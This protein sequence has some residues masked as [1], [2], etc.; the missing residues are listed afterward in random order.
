MLKILVLKEWRMALRSQTLAATLFPL[1]VLLGIAFTAG[2]IQQSRLH[3]ERDSANAHFRMQWEQL[4]AGDPHSAAHFG[5]YLFKPLATLSSFDKGVDDISGYTMRVE[6]HIQ[7]SMATPP[8]RPADAYLRFG[9]LTMA[10]VLQLFFPLFILFYCYNSYTQEQAS[11]TLRLLLLQGV[12]KAAI[13]LGKAVLHLAL[14]NGMLLC[15]LLLYLPPLLLSGS[16]PV[17]IARILLLVICYACYGSIFLLLGMAVSAGARNGRQ[18]LII[19]AG[20]WLLWNVI[21]PRL[22]A[23]I[24]ERLHP[25]PSQHALQEKIEKAIRMG[26]HGDDPREE[27]MEKLR[28]RVLKQYQVSDERQLPVNF[29]AIRMQANEDYAQLVY[30]KYAA[31]T[32]SIIR[33]QH[34]ITRYVALADPYLAIRSISMTLCGTDYAHHWHFDTSARRYRNDFIRRLNMQLASKG[35]ADEN[36]YMA[37]PQFDY[38]PPDTFTVLRGQVW[39]LLSLLLWLPLSFLLLKIAA[40]YETFL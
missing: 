34:S 25:L 18:S 27:R 38:H 26:I 31:A 10:S 4:K 2:C 9:N 3:L 19:L 17:S 21:A 29:D 1:L 35:K 15:G 5:T 11:G 32:D 6:A 13:L 40:G 23:A 20:I 7:H 28:E 22:T 37:T 24:G 12:G 16:T 36:F 30:D 8:L 39:Q 14:V 33:L